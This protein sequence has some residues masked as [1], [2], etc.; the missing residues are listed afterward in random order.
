MAK[1]SES[2]SI[3]DEHYLSPG[4]EQELRTIENHDSKPSLNLYWNSADVSSSEDGTADTVPGD[5]TTIVHSASDNGGGGAA[6]E[7]SKVTLKREITTFSGV[8]VA[9]ISL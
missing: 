6:E 3:A 9:S 2:C 7:H 5:L 4:S 8:F 1:T